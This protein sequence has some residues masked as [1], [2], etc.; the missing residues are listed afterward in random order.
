VLLPCKICLS[1]HCLY[2]EPP[3]I[4]RGVRLA[5]ERL[6]PLR[7]PEVDASTIIGYLCRT[8]DVLWAWWLRLASGSLGRLIRLGMP[9][10]S[11]TIVMHRTVACRQVARQLAAMQARLHSTAL[12]AETHSPFTS[13]VNGPGWTALT[14]SEVSSTRQ[15]IR[16][17]C[18]V[19]TGPGPLAGGPHP[20]NLRVS[21]LQEVRQE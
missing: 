7:P 9:M 21:I 11:R 4:I 3:E 15:P 6:V 18:G 5:A 20:G 16:I 12:P 1:D 19:E 8:N 13:A 2:V 17:V 10:R 14:K